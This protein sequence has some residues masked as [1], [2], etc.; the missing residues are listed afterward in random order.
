M[1]HAIAELAVSQGNLAVEQFALIQL[2]GDSFIGRG[3]QLL[4][5]I[6]ALGKAC[7]AGHVFLEC[8]VE[9]HEAV[10]RLA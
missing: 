10:E 3:K 7:A 6:Q 5:V 4:Q 9:L 8:W 1:V 2:I